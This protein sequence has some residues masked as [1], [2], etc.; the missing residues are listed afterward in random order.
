MA[1][2]SGAFEHEGTIPDAYSCDGADISPELNW[3]GVPEGTQSLVLILDDPDAPG[4]TFTHWVIYNIPAA[5]TGLEENIPKTAELVSGALQGRN[6]IGEI[7]YG[8]P[9]PPLGQSHR[10]FFKLYALDIT[11]DLEGGASKAQVMAAMEGHILAEA[12]I[13]GNFQS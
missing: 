13:M 9:C 2:T 4:G 11:L 6:S 12:E 8:G 7:G 5:A 10:Y 1:I 3:T